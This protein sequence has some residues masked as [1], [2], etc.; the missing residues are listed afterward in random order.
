MPKDLKG[1]QAIEG[2]FRMFVAGFS[3]VSFNAA[4]SWPAGDYV[5][6]QG[7]IT[8]TNSGNL[9]MMK[10]KKTG[11]PIEIHTAE[12][13]L[14]QGGKIKQLWWFGNGA[15]MATQLGLE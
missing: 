9:P 4:V 3:N 2:L 13:A 7:T 14:V 1:K 15:E 11:K 6:S 10:L 8:G 5:F 12:I